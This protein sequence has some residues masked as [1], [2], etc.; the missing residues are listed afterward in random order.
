MGLAIVSLVPAVF[1]SVVIEITA[2]WLGKPLSTAAV[3]MMGA[4]IGL[5][6]LAVCAPLMLRNAGPGHRR[7]AIAS[8][9]KPNN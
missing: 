2:Q 3:A 4:T 7:M 1:W 9:G 8:R 5:F 6:L